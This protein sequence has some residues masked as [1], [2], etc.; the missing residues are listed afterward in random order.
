MS[1]P[2]IHP[3]DKSYVIT[4]DQINDTLYGNFYNSSTS[5]YTFQGSS[6]A[7]DSTGVT[8]LTN[9]STRG[10]QP[11][12]KTKLTSEDIVKTWNFDPISPSYKLHPYFL[13]KGKNDEYK[14]VYIS[15]VHNL[16][17]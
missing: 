17:D 15:K 6:A 13:I 3:D 11:T 4:L 10:K 16:D 5:T 2:K 1:Y 14:D 7:K 8:Y 12:L 9:E